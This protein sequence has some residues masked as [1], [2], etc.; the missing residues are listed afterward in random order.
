MQ[1]RY[2]F[3]VRL[4]RLGAKTGS[5]DS[6]CR[7]ENSDVKAAEPRPV[8]PLLADG[9]SP[10]KAGLSWGCVSAMDRDR[11]TILIAFPTGRRR[12]LFDF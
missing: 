4:V 8:N 1:V 9:Q 3:A 10:S 6:N 7:Y 2:A 5:Q 11:R 12:E